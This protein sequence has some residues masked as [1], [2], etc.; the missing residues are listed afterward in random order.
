LL[1]VLLAGCAGS[2]PPL[3]PDTTSVNRTR[4]I[5]RSDFS[6]ED[7][8]ASC[9]SIA[10]ERDR[11]AEAMRSANASIEGNRPRDQVALYFGGVLAAPFIANTNDPERKAVNDL[12]LRQDTL[13]KLAAVKGC[14]AGAN[15]R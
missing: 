14:P 3:P 8:A 9:V 11:N 4:S 6:P 10:A 2:A 1:L 12:Y 5:T 15:H 13:I 7:Q